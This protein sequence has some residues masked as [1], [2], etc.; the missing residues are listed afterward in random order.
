[1]L[2]A[3]VTLSTT[4]AEYMAMEEG[5]KEALWLWGLLDDLGLKQD[6]VNLNCDS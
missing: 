5:V 6:C 3:T 4:E 1:M 2:Q